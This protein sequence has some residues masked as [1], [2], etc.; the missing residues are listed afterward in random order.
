MKRLAWTKSP[1]KKE[2]LWAAERLA[3][4]ANA[5]E[6]GVAK[7]QLTNADFFPTGFWAALDP[8]RPRT[9]TLG[10]ARNTIPTMRDADD[11]VVMPHWWGIQQG[12]RRAWEEG[13]PPDWSAILI[14]LTQSKTSAQ[15]WPYQRALMFMAIE[16]WRARFCGICGERFVAEKPARRFCSNQCASDAR[17]M[18]RTAWWH[19]HGEKWRRKRA[20]RRTSKRGEK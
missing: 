17:R 6:S 3:L 16:S 5:D 4:F 11:S 7:F 9:L 18:S 15:A 10:S 12:L 19:E 1:N 2:L 20:M 13:F 14:A 8:Q